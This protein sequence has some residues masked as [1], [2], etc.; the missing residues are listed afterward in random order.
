MVEVGA[1]RERARGVDPVVVREAIDATSRRTQRRSKRATWT[2]WWGGG[3]LPMRCRG[4][5]GG[6][7][8]VWCGPD[9]RQGGG[10]RGT[11]VDLAMI[12]EVVREAP[13]WTRQW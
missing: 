5:C 8:G 9:R 4:S 3:R 13:M 2:K 12:D 10:R 7:A 6:G 1:E 11:N